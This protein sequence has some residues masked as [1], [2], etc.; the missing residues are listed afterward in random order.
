L[1]FRK[2]K[3]KHYFWSNQKLFLMKKIISSQ[4]VLTIILMMV[5]LQAN[6]QKFYVTL[7]AGYGL[8]ATSNRMGSD[9]NSNSTSSKLDIYDGVNTSHSTTYSSVYDSKNLKGTGSYGKGIRTAAIF[10]YMITENFGAEL[11]IDYLMGSNIT[12]Y[13]SH[14]ITTENTTFQ[15][16]T[17]SN[18]NTFTSLVHTSS[19]E[20]KVKGNMLRFIPA[21]RIT[22]GDWKVKPYMKFGLVI[23]ILNKMQKD[24]N[25]TEVNTAGVEK[26]KEQTEIGKGNVSFGF[27]AALGVNYEFA[28]NFGVFGEVGLI[29]QHYAPAKSKLTKF[30]VDGVDQLPGMTT[31]D[32]ETVF[33]DHYS[34]QSP[35]SPDADNQPYETTKDY[36]PFSSIGLNI[37]ITWSF[38]GK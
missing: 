5:V 34:H 29:A 17:N 11:G 15:D 3:E 6:S 35:S 26:V 20:I 32:I 37:G 8:S 2:K 10:G 1:I 18:N 38:G 23:S 25:T 16:Q 31:S 9:Y 22:A 13:K 33:V 4:I 36:Y 14:Y 28:E 24:D 21:V 19:E 27:A 30:T 7:G 12:R